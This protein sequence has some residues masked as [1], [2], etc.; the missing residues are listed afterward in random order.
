M[1]KVDQFI[2]SFISES[3]LFFKTNLLMLVCPKK[4][5]RIAY[6]RSK[7]NKFIIQNKYLFF[8]ISCFFFFLIQ[9]ILEINLTDIF[10]YLFSNRLYFIDY[11]VFLNHIKD[12]IL[13]YKFNITEIFYFIFPIGFIPLIIAWA[14]VKLLNADRY[15]SYIVYFLSL[16][17]NIFTISVVNFA[18]SFAIINSPFTELPY[19]LSALFFCALFLYILLCFIRFMIKNYREKNFFRKIVVIL[20]I[21]SNIILLSE[22]INLKNRINK[23]LQKKDPITA[24][25]LIVDNQ[26]FKFRII[27]N[28]KQSTFNL[29][30]VIYNHTDENLI[31]MNNSIG[32]MKYKTN[33]KNISLNLMTKRRLG[34]N[35]ITNIPA[36]A[37]IG[38]DLFANLSMESL[39]G[40][41]EM[42]AIQNTKNI[43]FPAEIKIVIKSGKGKKIIIKQIHAYRL[44][45]LQI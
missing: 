44:N 1:N 7:R 16:Q 37:A 34:N 3:I 2:E 6:A 26:G 28:G 41:K 10:K 20:L 13:N 12:N 35:F 42:I 14:I 4:F 33:G 11:Q 40:L 39:A 8:L 24:K 25:V 36:G 17:I 29:T 45:E 27:T 5:H 21:T 23:F 30:L 15:Y 22:S 18:A 31:I 43:I 38:L 19:I 9:T 32:S